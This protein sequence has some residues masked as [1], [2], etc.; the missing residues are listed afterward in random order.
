MSAPADWLIA[1]CHSN[2]SS[3]LIMNILILH[4]VSGSVCSTI[5]EE[6]LKLA[7]FGRCLKVQI[8]ALFFLFFT[9]EKALY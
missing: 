1:V 5:G 6:A 8:I 2:F 3:I 4:F 7:A 9:V